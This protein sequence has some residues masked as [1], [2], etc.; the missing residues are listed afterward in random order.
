MH[1]VD[2]GIED[3]DKADVGRRYLRAR[4]WVPED[5][6]V[7]LRDTTTWREANDIDTVYRTIELSSY[8]GARRMYPQWTGRRDKR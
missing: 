4:R 1:R 8:E 2:M 5:A 3:E 6:L 7:Q